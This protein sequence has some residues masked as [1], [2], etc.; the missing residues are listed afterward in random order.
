[1][2]N[3]KLPTSFDAMILLIGVIAPTT[4]SERDGEVVHCASHSGRVLS[5]HRRLDDPL[6][7]SPWWW[8]QGHRLATELDLVERL[9]WLVDAPRVAGPADVAK[10]LDTER[11]GSLALASRLGGQC[12]DALAMDSAAIFACSRALPN[13]DWTKHALVE[14]KSERLPGVA[15]NRDRPVGWRT[16]GRGALERWIMLDGKGYT[17]RVEIVA[18]E[19]RARRSSPDDAVGWVPFEPPAEPVAWLRAEAGVLLLAEPLPG[20]DVVYVPQPSRSAP[21]ERSERVAD[22]L[23]IV[24]EFNRGDITY[25]QAE[26]LLDTAMPGMPDGERE[27]LL[28][29]TP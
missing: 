26:A 24:K 7:S 13:N 14:T 25:L 29:R 19:I 6:S 11:R 28:T 23:A 16:N 2:I 12:V 4:T 9:C 5:F 27:R 21:S 3:D 15:Q 17:E 10:M 22:M 18:G 8:V 20:G 1:M